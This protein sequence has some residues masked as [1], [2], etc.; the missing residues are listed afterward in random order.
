MDTFTFF[1]SNRITSLGFYSSFF[2]NEH[3]LLLTRYHQRNN[4]IMTFFFFPLSIIFF[5]GGFWYRFSFSFSGRKRSCSIHSSSSARPENA[6][7]FFYLIVENEFR[8]RSTTEQTAL[9]EEHEVVFV[10]PQLESGSPSTANQIEN[11]Q[12]VIT[13]M[14]HEIKGYILFQSKP[15]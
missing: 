3:Q 5:F 12:G 11:K 8:A 2:T 6:V 1:T 7:S 13:R 4:P 14:N 15:K 9:F 10:S